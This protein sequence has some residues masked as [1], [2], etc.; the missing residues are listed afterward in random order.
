MET[1]IHIQLVTATAEPVEIEVAALR[2][3]QELLSLDVDDVRPVEG[4]VAPA[5]SR[6]A[7]IA[8]AGAL[9]LTL[10]KSLPLVRQVL[11]AVRSWAQREPV[12]RNA[13]LTIGDKTIELTGVSSAQQDRLITEFLRAMSLETPL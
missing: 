13:R 8:V 7:D 3:R 5:G 1:T 11:E 9:L 2:L 10:K 4:G 6:A 12:C